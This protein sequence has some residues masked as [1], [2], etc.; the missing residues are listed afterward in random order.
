MDLIMK[1]CRIQRNKKASK[2]EMTMKKALC[3]F[4]II[5]ELHYINLVTLA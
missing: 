2:K 1:Q 5:S 3:Y 4:L